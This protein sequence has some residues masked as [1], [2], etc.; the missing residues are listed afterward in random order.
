MAVLG[1]SGLSPLSLN[2]A[3]TYSDILFEISTILMAAAMI[4]LALTKVGNPEIGHRQ[5]FSIVKLIS[6]LPTGVTCCFYL[7]PLTGGFYSLLPVY[8]GRSTARR[9]SCP[10]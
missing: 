8:V 1:A 6:A 4:P 5:S 7:G 2:I 3:N 9:G 10:C